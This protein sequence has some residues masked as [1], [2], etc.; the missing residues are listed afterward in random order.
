MYLINAIKRY[1]SRSVSFTTPGHSQGKAVLPQVRDL[2]GI[3]AFKADLSE[4]TGMDNAHN[5]TGII[6]Q[7]QMR[8]SEVYGS[9]FSYYLYNGSTSGILALMLTT[10]RQ[11]EKVLIARNAHKSVIN[12][13]ILSGAMPVWLNT[14]W[15]DEWNIPGVVGT[16]KIRESLETN[17]DIKA[18]WL[19]NPSYEGVVT[20]IAPVVQICK[21][22]EVMLLVDEAH[23]ALWN[24]SNKLPSIA[25][26]QGADASVQSLHKTASGLTQGSILHL[27]SNTKINPDELQYNLNIVNTTSPSYLILAGIEGAIKYLRSKQGL[28]KLEELL[29]NVQKFR[30]TLSKYPDISILSQSANY[31]IDPTKL[32]FGINDLNGYDLSKYLYEKYNIEVELDNNRG[33]LALTGIGTSKA[34]IDKLA[35]AVI[36]L[37]KLVST[38]KNENILPQI[39]PKVVF[40]PREAFYKKTRKMKLSDSLGL[41]SK[42]TIVHYPPGVPNIVA[43]EKIQEGHIELLKDMQEISIILD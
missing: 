31:T 16:E 2:I 26:Q 6:L 24:F 9:K 18:L 42:E 1:S 34:N 10:V 39:T 20:D 7:S 3:K 19:T 36:K 21:E 5:P 28:I 25:T 41:I 27:G 38:E 15:I 8:A 40:S 33:V 4:V 17:P 35:V 29:K 30:K 32:F 23:G 14:D 22:K 37:Q 43:G 12:A 13:L 11:G